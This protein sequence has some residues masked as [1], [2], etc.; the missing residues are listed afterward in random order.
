MK[1]M[2]I[3]GRRGF[4]LAAVL[5]A[6]VTFGGAACAQGTQYPKPTELPNPYRLVAGWP[7]LPKSMNGGHWG[8]VIRVHVDS[9]GNIWVFHRCFNVVS[10]SSAT[11][12]NVGQENP[13]NLV[14]DWSGKPLK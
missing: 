8:E 14:F 1:V 9:K 7:T 6:I 4:M 3:I 13:P 2:R 11:C 12:I 5:A 10:T